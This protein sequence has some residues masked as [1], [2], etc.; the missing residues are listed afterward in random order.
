MINKQYQAP[1]NMAEANQKWGKIVEKLVGTNPADASKREAMVEYAQIHADHIAS[2]M[3]K[4]SSGGVAYSNPANT[5]GMGAVVQPGLTGVPGLP[6]T[7]GSGDLTQSLLP[8]ALKIWAQTPGLDLIKTINVNSNKVSLLYF[9]WQYDDNGSLDNDE[10]VT[11]F[12]VAPNA[13][14]DLTALQAYLRAEMVSNNV[15]ELRGRLSKFLYFNI[16]MPAV[17]AT[18]TSPAAPLFAGVAPGYDCTVA[19]VGS[20]QGWLQFVGFGRIDGLPMFRA[21]IQVNT[22]S[23]GQFGFNQALN[24]FPPVGTIAAI[25]LGASIIATATGAGIALAPTSTG[26]NPSLCSLAEEFIDGFTT[27]R[28][29]GPITRGTWDATEADKIGPVST[30]KDIEIGVAHVKASLRL[31]EL[32]DYKKMYGINIIERTKA[33]CINLMSQTISTEIVENL[34]TLGLTNRATLQPHGV[35]YSAGNWGNITDPRIFD[36]SVPAVSA[37]LGGEQNA[38]IVNK[39]VRTLTTASYYIANDGRIGAAEYIVTSAS[40]AAMFKTVERYMF[41]PM[42]IKM[43]GARQL[44][45]AGSVDGMKIYVDPYMEPND[46]TFFLGRVGTAEEPGAKFLAYILAQ[47][48]EIVSE[49]TMGHTMYM[50]SRY[51]IANLGWF[52]EKQYMAVKVFDPIGILA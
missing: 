44:Q 23:S 37:A 22:A 52:P 16:S 4:E 7:A 5:A 6:G 10:R 13:T 35:P 45:P 34:K 41:N 51:A 28:Q 40:G 47:N 24:T 36:V 49:A 18:A 32:D 39:A 46:L 38:S 1:V 14:A 9:D 27:G 15:I 20:V 43:S 11:T 12:K 33:Q 30:V 50:Y 42:D 25:T 17:A 3:I 19:P 26:T 31:S 21:Y 8:G 2:N 48:V 29:K